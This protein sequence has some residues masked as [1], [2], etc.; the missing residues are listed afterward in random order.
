MLES[1]L[2]DIGRI[3]LEENY[4]GSLSLSYRYDGTHGLSLGLPLLI[5][6]NVELPMTGGWAV[7]R[8]YLTNNFRNF[9]FTLLFTPSASRWL[10]GYF[11]VGTEHVTGAWDASHP[12]KTVN[13]WEFLIESGIKIR[14]NIS[15][16]VLRPMRK[17]GT[18]FWGIRLGIRNFGFPEINRLAFI[19]EIGAGVW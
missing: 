10:D 7:H 4:L 18:E 13:K 12:G 19:V 16:T 15:H 17:L 3:L 1:P 2:E 5:F 11:T 14:V 6:K 8:L 9:G